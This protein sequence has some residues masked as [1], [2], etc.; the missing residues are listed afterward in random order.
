MDSRAGGWWRRGEE[1]RSE[2]ETTG[3]HR[4]DPK[5]DPDRK[6]GKVK[7]CGQM[8]GGRETRERLDREFSIGKEVRTLKERARGL[9]VV[10]LCLPETGD[11]NK[12]IKKES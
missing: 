1:E 6:A 11:E 4:G 9:N 8:R 2:R 3:G 5:L 10:R 12:H 7:G